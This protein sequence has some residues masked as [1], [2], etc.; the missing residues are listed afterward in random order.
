[1]INISLFCGAG[2]PV[3]NKEK[4][5]LLAFKTGVLLAENEYSLV[6]GGGMGMMNETCRGVRSVG[7]QTVGICLDKKGQLHGKHLLNKIFYKTLFKRQQKII[8]L[9]SAYIFLPGGL[10]TLY[11]FA[12]IIERKRI[13]E[14]PEDRP[15]II[16]GEYYDYLNKFITQNHLFGFLPEETDRYFVNVMRPEDAVDIINKK[17]K[18]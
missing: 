9:G 4:L 7:G 8:S 6:C 3:K 17:L 16:V 18:G 13:G 11:E 14:I 12:E 15:T 10:G 1:M 2:T 5:L